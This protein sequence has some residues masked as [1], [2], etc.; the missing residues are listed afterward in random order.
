MQLCLKEFLKVLQLTAKLSRWHKCLCVCV[1][2]V[3]L[4]KE[5]GA[6]DFLPVLSYVIVQCNM[7]E[8]LFEVEYMMEL[9]DTP[10]LTGEG[11]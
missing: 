2:N 10:W 1:F 9:L 3:I 8:L 11:M 4:G 5:F 6:D 7:P